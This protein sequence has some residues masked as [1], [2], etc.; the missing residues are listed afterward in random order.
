L[1]AGTNGRLLLAL[2]LIPAPAAAQGVLD[3]FTYDGL[4]F[5]GI[6]LDAGGVFSNKLDGAPSGAVRLDLGFFA[7]R[8]RPL[9]SLSFFRSDYAAD[10][11][12]ELETRLRGIVDDPTDDFTIDAGDVSLSTLALDVDLQFMPIQSGPVRPYVGLGAGAHLRFAEG[13]AI[14]GTFIEDALETVVAALNASAGFEVVVSP[15]LHVTVEGRGMLASGL[16]AVSARGGFLLRF[17]RRGA[18]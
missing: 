1:N 9:I 14:E 13:P 3:D 12:A 8:V 11:I 2:V 10:E 16:T 15:S 4:Y 7:P 5:A 17:P 18:R 6:G